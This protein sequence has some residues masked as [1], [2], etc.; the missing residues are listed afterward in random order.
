MNSCVNRRHWTAILGV[1]RSAFYP[2]VRKQGPH[3]W[4]F[5]SAK[6]PLVGPQ[7]RKIPE[8]STRY[9]GTWPCRQV[10]TMT[11]SLYTTGSGTSSQCSMVWRS[12]DK[13]QSD[14]WVPLTT[15][16][17]AFNTRCN[18]LSRR[19]RRAHQDC[20]AVVSARRTN[21][22]VWPQILC[23]VNAEI[24]EVDVTSRNW[25]RWRSRQGSGVCAWSCYHLANG[26]KTCSR[27]FTHVISY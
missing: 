16:A 8:A 4:I 3:F 9:G 13:P 19:F 6:Y 24:A 22:R 15:R 20:V 1:H 21:V 12:R 11:P 10:N 2:S 23:Q 26:N 18:L 25:T 5:R 7:V 27:S 17:A 14:L